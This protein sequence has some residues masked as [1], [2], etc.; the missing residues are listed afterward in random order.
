MGSSESSSRREPKMSKPAFEVPS[1]FCSTD[2]HLEENSIIIRLDSNNISFSDA[3]PRFGAFESAFTQHEYSYYI[4]QI[5]K[6]CDHYRKI[7]Q[8]HQKM[9][10]SCDYLD[11]E[12]E[13]FRIVREMSAVQE[14]TFHKVRSIL[15]QWNNKAFHAK[16]YHWDCR[17]FSRFVGVGDRKSTRVPELVITSWGV[18]NHRLTELSSVKDRLTRLHEYHDNG[19]VTNNQFNTCKNL[20]TIEQEQYRKY[21]SFN[22]VLD[23]GERKPEYPPLSFIK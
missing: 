5:N 20:L 12:P 22:F 18:N 23:A 21:S 14:E 10:T 9:I 1:H 7:A 19:M 16:G 3:Q 4:D 6:Q 13:F 2:P 11:D 17:L 8:E 15:A